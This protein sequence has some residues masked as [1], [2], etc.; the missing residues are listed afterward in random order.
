MSAYI[1][2]YE[3][4]T[5]EEA[6]ILHS[7]HYFTSIEQAIKEAVDEAANVNFDV[8]DLKTLKVVFS[9]TTGEKK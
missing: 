3:T 8:L 7:N 1:L 9:G 4:E 6:I 2:K 5:V